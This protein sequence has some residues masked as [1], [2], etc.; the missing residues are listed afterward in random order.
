MT[1]PYSLQPKG[2]RI[3]GLKNF[4]VDSGHF[5]APTGRVAA[6]HVLKPVLVGLSKKFAVLHDDVKRPVLVSRQK[7]AADL[8]VCRSHGLPFIA[9][10]SRVE[11]F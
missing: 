9:T 2:R 10:K 5:D 11:L 6:P 8:A 3:H 4:L 7:I 1:A